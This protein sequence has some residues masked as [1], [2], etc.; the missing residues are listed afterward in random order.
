VGTAK[1]ERQKANRQLRLEEVQKTQMKAKRKRNLLRY[2]I[3]LV[4]V[5]GLII[6]WAELSKKD[7]TKVAT[8]T[9]TTTA[10]APTTTLT[11]RTIT[12]PTPCPKADG[13]EE[14][15]I[16]FEQAP[17]TCIDP[18]KTYTATIVTNMGTVT[19]ALDVKNAPKTVN[20]FV[21]L[22]RY[23]YY[24][25]V[26]CHRIIP[27][28][29]AQCGDPTGTGGGKNPGYTF[30]DENQPADKK[31]L[32][33]Q[34]VMANA[35]PNTNGS[36]FFMLFADYNPPSG[37]YNVFGTTSADSAATLTALEA[38]ADP[39]ASNGSPTKVPVSTTSVTITES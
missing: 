28:F 5:V 8:T 1:R 20:N 6:L 3:G 26:P 35:G 12:G 23:H 24:D 30:A 19:A 25:S 34:I 2:G 17:P 21:V 13:S 36:Q 37:G 32:K 11:G 38:A 29:M 33:G 27:S 14:R 4:V 10:P 18:A 31:Y 9:T 22:A 7:T 15:A 16:L 39:N